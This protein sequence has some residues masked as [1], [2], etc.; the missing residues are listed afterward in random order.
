VGLDFRQVHATVLEDWLG[1]PAKTTLGA[2]F[3]KLP[4]IRA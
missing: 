3:V 2:P 4:L 1:L